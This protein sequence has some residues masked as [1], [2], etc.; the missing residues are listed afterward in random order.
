MA[1]FIQELRQELD[2]DFYFLGVLEACLR[3]E[4]RFARVEWMAAVD[5]GMLLAL[6]L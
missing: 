2:M 5:A 6:Q 1:P 4:H 3:L